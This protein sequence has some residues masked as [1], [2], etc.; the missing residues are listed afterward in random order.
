VAVA[1]A[2]PTTLTRRAVLRPCTVPM[3]AS[4]R[5]PRGRKMKPPPKTTYALSVL[6]NRSEDGKNSFPIC[7]DRKAKTPKSN[8][9]STLP[10]ALA[11]MAL[12][13]LGSLRSS[14][15][16]GRVAGSSEVSTGTLRERPGRHTLSN[17]HSSTSTHTP[18]YT[19]HTTHTHTHT[20]TQPTMHHALCIQL[21]HAHT[22]DAR[23]AHA[24][25][26]MHAHT[27]TRVR[28]STWHTQQCPC[29]H[30]ASR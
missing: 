20:H 8:H 9:S 11:I 27:H 16:G 13:T 4:T 17:V 6:T 23:L 25:T 19:P 24:H 28:A 3:W 18:T 15:G 29:R 12:R 10:T 2:I 1:P 14:G 7:G 21:H 5:P 26:N 30:T 22:H